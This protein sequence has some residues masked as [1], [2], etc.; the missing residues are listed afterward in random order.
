[1]NT[2]LQD[3][4]YGLRMLR[5][6]PGFTL[7][8]VLSLALG[9]GA[10]TAIFQLLNAVR[11]RLLPVER[12]HELALVRIANRQGA[13][14]NF[15]GWYAYL[16]H[17]QWERIRDRQQAFSGI[18][19]WGTA[20]FNLAVSGE[21]RF[22]ENCLWVSG[23][24]FNVLGVRPLLGRV[25]TPSDDQRGCGSSGV[26]LSY[27][28]WQRQFGG[29]ASVIGK[30]ITL[31][32]HP[33]EVIGVTPA[34]FFGVEVGRQY[35]LAIPICADALLN[36]ERNRLDRRS[37]WW[38]AAIG[39]LKPGWTLEQA[40]SQLSSIS[41]A[42]FQETLH[43]GWNAETRE[44]Y[45]G[46]KLEAASGGTG[47]SRL[48][49]QYDTPLWLLLA[50]A[51]A[52]LLIACANLANL[53][54]ARASTR[55]REI[56]VRLALGASRGRL[57]RQLLTESLL[58]ATL[59]AIVGIW[60]APTLSQSVVT[61][62][63]TEVNPL[64][65]ALDTDWRVL[66]FTAGLAMLTCLLF[67]LA[68]SLRATKT[69]PIEAM[70]AGSRSL[71]A[72]RERFGLR[73]MLVVSQVALSLVLLVGA[74]LFVRSLYNLLTLDAGFQQDGILEVDVN[75]ARLNLPAERR[76]AFQE[77][78]RARLRAIPGVEAAA[79]V[80]GVP[81]VGR[82]NETVYLG[83]GGEMRKAESYFN[84]VSLDYFKTLGVLLMAGRD[85]DERDIVTSPKVAII[86]ES[87]ARQ[88]LS[89]RSPLGATFRLEGSR[90][91]PETAY[92]IVGVV[93]NTKYLDLREDFKP[94]VFL[95]MS[96][97]EQP[98]TFDQYLLRSHLPLASLMTS[99]KQSISGAYPE[100]SFHFHDFKAQ[101][102]ESLVQERMMAAF[103]GFFGLLAALLSIIG[104]Y[105]V[106]SYMVT[107]R[108][109]EIGIRLA[110]G[111]NGSDIVKM[112]MREAVVLLT[113][114]LMVGTVLT[115]IV[116]KTSGALLE[117][118]AVRMTG[119]LLFG[120]Q[121]HDLATFIM[122]AALL[123]AVAIMASYVPA[124]RAAGV[125][126]MVALRDE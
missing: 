79:S 100:T 45:L 67:G 103:A 106:I 39:R 36:G 85:F 27:A 10:N 89:G 121:P 101:I 108:R 87:F 42:L 6:N 50:I 41:S 47:V 93:K 123:A 84:R 15:N 115:L 31:N 59:G 43:E 120:L 23:D 98:G 8:A 70:K 25:F 51:G 5:K 102:R 112:I 126:P 73:R 18:A 104:L 24:F 122:A 20:N 116:T 65:V 38:L 119:S 99:V 29:E 46:Y 3:L 68:P 30:K 49:R 117:L 110:L 69:G 32:G 66:G 82:W 88:F 11:L 125:D 81:T 48:R 96:Q 19:A 58:L 34:S 12:P 54:L 86:N 21:D 1:M 61:L 22:A 37:T 53:L 76:H 74:L 17:P 124:R 62:I 13:S 7:V 114:G 72:S 80:S 94:I 60:L 107:Q 77:E 64:F 63:S 52:V 111:A 56:A 40:T 35:D 118:V 97:N 90:G 14:G 75:S 28:F 109:N 44:K 92:Q 57:I 55:Q 71:T 91:V 16:T 105:G 113:A 2:L 83:D 4:R 26:V 95:A 9:I 78:V 33:F